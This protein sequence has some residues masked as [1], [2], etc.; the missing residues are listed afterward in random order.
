M[1]R[2]RKEAVMVASGVAY[3]P[4]IR[5]EELKPPLPQENLSQENVCRSQELN[6]VPHITVQLGYPVGYLTL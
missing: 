2:M 3:Y 4:S 6:R 5:Q 1:E